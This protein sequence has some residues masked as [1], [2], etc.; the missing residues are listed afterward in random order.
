MRNLNISWPSVACAGFM[1]AAIYVAFVG[2]TP[3]E[4]NLS[5]IL[6]L[7]A[8]ATALLALRDR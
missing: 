1:A 7:C 5:L 2:D 6:A 3:K 4:L 8:V